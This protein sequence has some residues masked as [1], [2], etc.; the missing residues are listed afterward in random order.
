M[1]N[2][3]TLTRAEFALALVEA[4]LDVQAFVPERVIPP[5]VIMNAGSP[6]LTPSNI[7]NDYQLNIDLTLVASTATNEVETEALDQL[8]QDT[9]TAIAPINYADFKDVS[10]PFI[11]S[12]N[13]ADYLAA[14]LTLNLY[15]NL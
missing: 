4:G 14:T 6:Y 5:V 10:K 9:I 1:T 3:I 7:S 15:I 2:E 13:N 8:I 11:L 12:A